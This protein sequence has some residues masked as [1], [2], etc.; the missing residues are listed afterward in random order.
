MFNATI[1]I[2]TNDPMNAAVDIPVTAGFNMLACDFDVQPSR[3][4]FGLV[5]PP[6]RR[7]L[8]A[9]LRNRGQ[10]VCNFVSGDFRAP[11]EAS[12]TALAVSYPFSL[13]PGASTN[14]VF[15]FAPTD[16]REVK[17][18]YDLRTDE[19]IFSAHPI[20][21]VGSS[22]SYDRSLR[23]AR[24]CRLWSG[25]AQLRALW[26][27]SDLVQRGHSGGD[28]RSHHDYHHHRGASAPR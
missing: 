8:S 6:G 3:V 21:I 17:V 22:K 12:V 4:N 23:A 25:H 11:A 14:L 18:T 20:N 26:G 27:G 15:T 28:P 1:H 24:V 9:T 10:Q 2:T 19:A 5:L 16:N 13:A 7:T